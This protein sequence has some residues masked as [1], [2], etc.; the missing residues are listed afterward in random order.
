[1]TITLFA[2]TDWVVWA[3][4][5]G[6]ILAVAIPV[7][8]IVFLILLL[9][10]SLL[11]PANPAGKAAGRNLTPYVIAGAGLVFVVV[12]I[13]GSKYSERSK[14]LDSL[15]LAL[16][17]VFGVLASQRRYLQEARVAWAL[18]VP[19]AALVFLVNHYYL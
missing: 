1:M 2:E 13:A 9:V 7:T 15:L 14:V 8:V 6:P 3:F 17:F 10:R 4:I 12:N 18:L 5:F 19:I 11:K 16:P